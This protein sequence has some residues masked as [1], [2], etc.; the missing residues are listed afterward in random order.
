MPVRRP[1]DGV[2]PLGVPGQHPGRVR[3]LQ[4]PQADL[5]V[6][7]R[8][9]QPRAR[10]VE[11]DAVDALGLTLEDDLGLPARGRIDA[12]RPVQAGGRQEAAVGR[13][14]ERRDDVGVAGEDRFDAAVL[15][16]EDVDQDA[17][18]AAADGHTAER[19]PLAVGA[20]GRGGVGPLVAGADRE[21][22]GAQGL[23][24]QHVPHAHALVE[25]DGD[26]LPGVRREEDLLD[27]AG[28]AARVEDQNGPS[29]RRRQRRNDRCGA[30]I[31]AEVGGGGAAVA[32]AR[33]RG[34]GNGGGGRV[35]SVRGRGAGGACATGADSPRGHRATAA[36]PRPARSR[37]PPTTA[38]MRTALTGARV[39]AACAA[40]RRTEA[41][42]VRRRRRSSPAPPR[43]FVPI[44]RPRRLAGG[45]GL[46]RGAIPSSSRTGASPPRR[47]VVAHF[48]HFTSF[49]PAGDATCRSVRH[50][51][52][53]IRDMAHSRR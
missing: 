38:A 18:L 35:G 32:L 39:A 2:A 7:P 51:G 43:P 1:G 11:G 44:P 26:D 53:R 19:Q 8:R 41:A 25:G 13:E 3:R 34:W 9:R 31:G 16:R 29:L 20:E 28:V 42:A 46:R 6:P 33:P 5:G 4:V 37:K 36:T 50:F 48:G 52:Q 12:H 40:R 27:G 10:R 24:G 49:P 47:K 17:E 15:Q 23:P 45:H 21:P 22:E 30:E 14:G